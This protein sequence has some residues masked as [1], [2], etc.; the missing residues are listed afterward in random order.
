MALDFPSSPT[1]GQVYG[2]YYYNSAR[3]AWNALLP[4]ATPAFLTG[5]TLNYPTLIDALATSSTV[6]TTPLTVKGL[7]GQTV[8]LQEWKNDSGTTVAALTPLG[9]FI[10]YGANLMQSLV[11]TR[12]PLTVKGSSGQT[13][14]LQEWHNSSGTVLSSINSSGTLTAPS[15]VTSTN[16]TTTKTTNTNNNNIN[17]NNN[18]TLCQL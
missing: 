18:N 5:A 13:A 8:N 17:N 1:N 10:G 2:N 4:A 15:V 6:S 14:N 12:T 16:I 3:G 9:A 11:T 7:S